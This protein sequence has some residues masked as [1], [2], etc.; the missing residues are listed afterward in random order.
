MCRALHRWLPET[1]F[2]QIEAATGP[3]SSAAEEILE[4]YYLMKVGSLQFC[5]AAAFG[6]SFWEGFQSLALTLPVILWVKRA[7]RFRGGR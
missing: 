2:E 6:L 7:F 4:R 1:T 5:G 3:L